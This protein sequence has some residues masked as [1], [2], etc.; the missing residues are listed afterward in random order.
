MAA[1]GRHGAWHRLS[2]LRANR[3]S[4]AS[5]HLLGVSLSRW[6]KNASIKYLAVQAASAGGGVPNNS[7]ALPTKLKRFLLDQ[8]LPLALLL[9]MSVG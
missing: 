8:Y 5:V 4:H 1:R 3:Q 7:N 9:G 6:E 2:T